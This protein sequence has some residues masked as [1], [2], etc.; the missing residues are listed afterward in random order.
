MD[1]RQLVLMGCVDVR[2]GELHVSHQHMML[3]DLNEVYGRLVHIS[4][5]YLMRCERM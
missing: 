3:H 2:T 1:L 5:Q 4:K